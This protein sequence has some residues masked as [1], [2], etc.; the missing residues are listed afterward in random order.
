MDCRA[1]KGPLARWPATP[2]VDGDSGREPASAAPSD[3]GRSAP[4]SG[5]AVTGGASLCGAAGRAFPVASWG[6][7][8]RLPV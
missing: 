5:T 7:E 8:E 4:G 2:L 6:I 3:T 1:A